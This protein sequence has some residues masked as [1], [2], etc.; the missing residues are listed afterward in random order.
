LYTQRDGIYKIKTAEDN[1]RSGSIYSFC[2]TA[3]W[4][5]TK[6][7]L[8]RRTEVSDAFRESAAIQ[9][10]GGEEI[11]QELKINVTILKIEIQD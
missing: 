10:R 11:I 7:K 9:K 5:L 3:G 2:G 8:N 1:I 4:K 6:R